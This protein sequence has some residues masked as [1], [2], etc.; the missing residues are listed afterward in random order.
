MGESAVENVTS[1]KMT[2][3]VTVDPAKSQIGELLVREGLVKEED[4]AQA[5]H[6]QRQE[7]AQAQ[8]PLGMLLLK[9]GY[10]SEADLLKLLEHPE[11]RA[12]IEEMALDREMVDADQVHLGP[13]GIDLERARVDGIFEISSPNICAG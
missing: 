10:L 2:Q 1:L 3:T 4:V 7:V 13:A 5:M 11:L 8:L 12:S 9:K 6:I